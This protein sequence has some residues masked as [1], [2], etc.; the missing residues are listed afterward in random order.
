MAALLGLSVRAVRDLAAQGVLTPAV[1]RG[2]WRTLESLHA[3]IDR[4]R[5]QAAGRGANTS[6]VDERAKREA[7]EREIAA[8]KLAEI[9]GEVLTVE[10]TSA[11]W[12]ALCRKFRGLM[13]GFPAKARSTIPHLTPHDQQTMTEL[14]R[15]ALNDLADEVEQGLIGAEP[16]PLRAGDTP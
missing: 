3:S 12:A 6:L 11:M 15:D 16:E 7:I 14:M 2:R 9:K 8:I 5:N 4:L 1:G 10:E 13:L